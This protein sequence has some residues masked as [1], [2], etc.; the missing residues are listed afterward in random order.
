MVQ[1]RKKGTNLHLYQ[2]M[3]YLLKTSHHMQHTWGAFLESP[4]NFS[5]AKSHS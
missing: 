2:D 4:E 5:G 3:D 1:R